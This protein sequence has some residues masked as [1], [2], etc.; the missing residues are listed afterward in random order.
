MDLQ[1]GARFNRGLRSLVGAATTDF[2]FLAGLERPNLVDCVLRA[3]VVLQLPALH[4]DD[5]SRLPPR[6][7]FRKISD[8]YRPH[9]GVDGAHAIAVAFLAGPSA[10]D[11]HYLFDVEPVALQRT[12]LRH[13]HDVCAASRCRSDQGGAASFVWR[14]R[15]VVS[16]SVS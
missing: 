8:F 12:K 15:R 11:F 2:L 16:D 6:R 1:S 9:Y 14:L 4:G 13:L 7:R 3:G 10:L 5:L